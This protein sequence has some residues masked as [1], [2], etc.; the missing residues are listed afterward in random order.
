M[1]FVDS[2]TFLSGLWV[3]PEMFR[4]K[5]VCTLCKDSEEAL[6]GAACLQ[7]S[8]SSQIYAS[9]QASSPKVWLID[10]SFVIRQGSDLTH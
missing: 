6:K 5:L 9:D 7:T 10:F 4:I 3:W 8:F 1:A 2:Y